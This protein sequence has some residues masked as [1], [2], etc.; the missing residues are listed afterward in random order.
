MFYLSI[1]HYAF[2]STFQIYY[3]RDRLQKLNAKKKVSSLH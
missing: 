2:T 3:G 1:K